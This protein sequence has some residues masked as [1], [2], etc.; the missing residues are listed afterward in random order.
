M[1]GI[2]LRLGYGIAQGCF[3]SDFVLINF[4]FMSIVIVY[5]TLPVLTSLS[6]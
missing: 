4:V 1:A 3:L 2:P 6:D 5:V